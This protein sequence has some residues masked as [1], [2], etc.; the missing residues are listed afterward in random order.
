MPTALYYLASTIAQVL[1]AAIAF[2]GALVLYRRQSINASLAAAVDRMVHLLGQGT[3]VS[4]QLENWT[5]RDEFQLLLDYYADP[6]PD[7]PE[8]RPHYLEGPL[9]S[10]SA[11][12]QSR[13]ALMLDFQHALRDT[14]GVLAV[15]VIIIPLVPVLGEAIGALS[16]VAL[17]GG[18]LWCLRDYMR[19]VGGMS[20]EK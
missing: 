2:L 13:K 12:L 15:A 3:P 17:V 16:E 19:L 11:S 4:N 5:R 8:A 6:A 18:F 1:A 9:A 20:L 7:R 14:V 10:I